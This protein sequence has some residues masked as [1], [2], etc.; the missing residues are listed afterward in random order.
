M[1]KG[2]LVQTSSSPS[3]KSF[4][5]IYQNVPAAQ[6]A[7]LQEFRASHPY[8]QLSS[9]G[10][11]WEYISSGQGD[12]TILVLPG[13][14]STGESVFPLITALESN[15]HIIAPSY[16]L[17]LTMTGLCAGIAQI[18]EVENVGS[19]HV[20]GGS[21]GGL[22][23]QYF[24]R[25]H[26]GRARSLLLSHTFAFNPKYTK[27]YWFAGKLFPAVPQSLIFR[28]LKLRLDKLLLSKLRAANHPEAAF[29]RA[30]L[31]EAMTF[32]HLKEVALHQNK[33]LLDLAKQPRPTASDLNEWPGRILIIESEDDPAIKPSE[34]ARLRD[35]YPR[36]EVKT[37]LD[38]GHASSIL[39]RDEVV[40]TIKAFLDSIGTA[41][42]SH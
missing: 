30:Y 41:E 21:Y 42:R 9:S 32:G 4:D 35:L 10:A 39:K 2:V 31:E 6:V 38:A 1:M 16:P 14:L 26:P 24:G 28:L 19:A 29:W 3:G 40:S 11:N 8:K 23:A 22:V 36:A 13:A 33:C 34:R 27:P 15:Y 5:E 17:S 20:F 12:E 18:L 7:R 25:Q 37:F